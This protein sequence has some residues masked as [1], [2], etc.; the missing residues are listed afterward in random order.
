MRTIDVLHLTSSSKAD[1]FYSSLQSLKRDYQVY[2]SFNHTQLKRHQGVRPLLALVDNQSELELSAFEEPDSLTI[3][4]LAL[5]D[6]Q[7][8]KHQALL[9]HSL[10]ILISPFTTQDL[11]L[12]LG[13]LGKNA[14]HTP[15]QVSAQ[16]APSSGLAMVGQSERFLQML[17]ELKQIA[18]YEEVSVLIKGETGTGK[19]LAARGIHYESPR[20]DGPFVPVNCGALNDELFLS[21]LFGHEKGAFTDAKQTHKG[22]LEQANGGTIFL[23]EIDSLSP[24]AQVA[25]L[26][27]LQEQE[28]R[29]LGSQKLKKSDVRV[30]SASNQN[31]ESLIN[32]GSFREDLFYRL[33]ILDLELPPLRERLG[34]IEL[35]CQHFLDC[36]SRQYDQSE[37]KLHPTTLNWMLDYSWPGNIR[38]LENYLLR[39][40]ILTPS[41]YIY[42]PVTKGR[43]FQGHADLPEPSEALSCDGEFNVEKAKAVEQFERQYIHRVL[44]LTKGNVSLAAKRA[45]K[46]RRAFGRLVKKYGINRQLYLKEA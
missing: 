34:D 37:K 19:E 11:I 10:D 24:R 31:L 3:D 15:D 21:E 5:F 8:Q 18:Q 38:E 6:S 2:K 32:Q 42:V 13:T 43:P 22:L 33:D 28:F 12:K 9:P 41:E 36:F 1:E 39:M 27:F 26:R 23:D 4:L 35:L 7:P 46:E 16:I 20:R 44:K 25:L 17:D 14:I 40:F 30:I 29:P 45:G